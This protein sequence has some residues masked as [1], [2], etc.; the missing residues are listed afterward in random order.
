MP[1]PNHW[2]SWTGEISLWGLR[3]GGEGGPSVWGT[4]HQL[5]RQAAPRLPL[6][7]TMDKPSTNGLHQDQDIDGQPDA[8][9]GVR[10]TAPRA[11]GKPSQHE[12]DCRQQHC[13]NLQPYVQPQRP[14]RSS[15]VEAR[16]EDGSRYD[17]EEDKCAENSVCAHNG[18]ILCQSGESISHSCLIS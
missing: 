17:D 3:G 5:H 11:D 2:W 6:L 4:H 7:P 10:E 9:V 15:S 16:R 14:A 1:L 13:K 8:V 18:V 12:Y